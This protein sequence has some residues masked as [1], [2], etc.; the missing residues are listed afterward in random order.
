VLRDYGRKP[1]PTTF[2]YVGRVKSHKRIEDI[3]HLLAEYRLL[4][5]SARCKIVGLADNPA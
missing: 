5:P 3:L 1:S 2:L 4:D